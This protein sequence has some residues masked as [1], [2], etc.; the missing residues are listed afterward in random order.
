MQ[1]NLDEYNVIRFIPMQHNLDVY[2]VIRFIPMQ[3][4][5]DV[6]NVIR[7][8]P[9]QRNLEWV[10]WNGQTYR[11]QKRYWGRGPNFPSKVPNVD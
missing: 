2:N 7:F 11:K 8:I 6:Y 3:R 9:M 10:Q 5:L 1:R 4:Y